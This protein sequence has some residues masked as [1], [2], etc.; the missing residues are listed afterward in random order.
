MKSAGKH[1]IKPHGIG[2]KHG[3]SAMA[4][5]TETIDINYVDVA[6]THGEAFIK[7]VGAFVGERGHDTRD[8]LVVGDGA[9]LNAARGGGLR[10]KIIDHGIGNGRAAAALIAIP[11]GAGLL[12]IAA[13]VEEPVG[14]H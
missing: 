1:T 11:A 8:N 12:A 2:V 10:G 3:S 13:H 5:K 7:N 6:G 14:E 4:R 9:P